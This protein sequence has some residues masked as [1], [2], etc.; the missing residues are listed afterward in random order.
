MR[1]RLGCLSLDPLFERETPPDAYAECREDYESANERFSF[2]L[3]TL[4]Q[5]NRRARSGYLILTGNR[6]VMRRLSVKWITAMTS[7]SGLR[8][9]RRVLKYGGVSPFTGGPWIRENE[10]FEALA[11]FGLESNCL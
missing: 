5:S 11:F 8:S 2:T 7:L 10:Q 6:E 9:T 3:H 1:G 4:V